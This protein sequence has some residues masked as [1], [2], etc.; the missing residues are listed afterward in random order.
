ME[1]N[2]QKYL[3]GIILKTFFTDPST[4]DMLVLKGG[5]ALEIYGF[6]SRDSYD[7]DFTIRKMKEKAFEKLNPLLEKN[8]SNEF[9]DKGYHLFDFNFKIKPGVRDENTPHYWG[10][11]QID[12][13]VISLVERKKIDEKYNDLARRM[14]V[15]R[16]SASPFGENDSTKIS[17]DFSYHEYSDDRFEMKINE[18]E[19]VYTIKL[20]RPIIIVYEK[21]RALCQNIPGPHLPKYKTG[22]SRDLYDIYSI[23]FSETKYS[24]NEKDIYAEE[25]IYELK[26]IFEMKKVPLELLLSLDDSYET[27][28]KDFNDKFLQTTPQ[29]KDIG[30]EYLYNFT[31]NLMEQCHTVLSNKF[32]G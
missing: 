16:S 19:D 17:I 1:D 24:L 4:K 27:L 5:Q 13:K 2:H 3:R 26:K 23:I 18:A 20:Y 14:H 8:L 31:K 6:S 7:I 32:K 9:E 15:M 21:I 28:L 11:Y 10:G 29:A 25:N 12:F 22:R 30:F